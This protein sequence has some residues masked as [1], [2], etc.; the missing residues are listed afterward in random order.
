MKFFPFIADVGSN[1]TQEL[2]QD[3]V[4][5]FQG[6]YSPIGFDAILRMLFAVVIIVMLIRFLLPRML[7]KWTITNNTV[8]GKEILVLESKNLGT[9]Q[10]HLVEIRG[11][12]YLIGESAHGLRLIADVSETVHPFYSTPNESRSEH[13]S[14]FKDVFARLERL[15]K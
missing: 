13:D 12:S 5:A 2:K 6:D 11:N 10:V 8:S 1:L 3:A 7:K 14:E 15:G 4:P 9:S